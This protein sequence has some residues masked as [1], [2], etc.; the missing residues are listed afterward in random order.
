MTLLVTLLARSPGGEQFEDVGVLEADDREV[1]TIQRSYVTL[2]KALG[3]SQHSGVYKAEPEVGVGDHQLAE[4]HIVLGPQILDD[5]RA[6]ADVVQ[7]SPE[8]RGCYEAVEL[9]E[10]R[11]GNEPD[12]VPRT[13]HFRAARVILI[14]RVKQRDQ[15]PGV[16]YERNGGGS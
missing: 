12:P 2:A 4:P 3:Y 6:T 11:R 7:E 5:E 14:V 15:R 16:D 13:E 1:A 10:H 8:G 9:D